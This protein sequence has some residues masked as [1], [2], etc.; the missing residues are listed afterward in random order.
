MRLKDAL[1][2]QSVAQKSGAPAGNKNTAKE[3]GQNKGNNVTFVRG[4]A[5]TYAIARLERDRPE[6]F[7][8]G[9]WRRHTCSVKCR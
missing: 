9:R 3:K 5:A 4:T 7:L 2:N 8:S 6:S 1:A